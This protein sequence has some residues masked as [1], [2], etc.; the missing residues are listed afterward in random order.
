MKESFPTVYAQ[1]TRQNDRIVSLLSSVFQNQLS[2][3][4][5]PSILER[6]PSLLESNLTGVV[7]S[8]L[9]QQSET[10]QPKATAIFTMSDTLLVHTYQVIN[11]LGFKIPD[12]ISLISISDGGAPNYVY[13]K[14]THL[15]HSGFE[16]GH[17]ASNLLFNIIKGMAPAFSFYKIEAQLVE[18]DS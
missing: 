18:R 8:A 17:K 2:T 7:G 16:V 15:F 4:W 1:P 11:N 12:D 6:F 13:P 5:C 9:Q 3:R 14:V 10:C